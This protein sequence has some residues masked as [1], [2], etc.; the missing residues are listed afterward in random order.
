ML[1]VVTIFSASNYYECG[2]NKGSYLKLTGPDLSK[3]F[4]QYT[5]G[6]TK[7]LTFRERIGI[8]EESA[9]RELRTIVLS[10]MQRLEQG[11]RDADPNSTGKYEKDFPECNCDERGQSKSGRFFCSFFFFITAGLCFAPLFSGKTSPE[12]E[13]PRSPRRAPGNFN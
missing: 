12:I 1:Q 11:F 10:S 7:T 13:S 5:A 4:V 8:V 2:S 9:I 3:Q 6:H